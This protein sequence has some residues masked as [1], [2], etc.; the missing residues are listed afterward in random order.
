MQFEG[1]DALWRSLMAE[2]R[3]DVMSRGG[4][5]TVLAPEIYRPRWSTVEAYFE[6]AITLDELLQALGCE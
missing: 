2:V 6:R 4:T 3:L 1:A 5:G